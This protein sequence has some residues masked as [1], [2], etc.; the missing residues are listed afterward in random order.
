MAKKF[1]FFSRSPLFL[2][3]AFPFR[4]FFDTGTFGDAGVVVGF[5]IAAADRVVLHGADAVGF[6]VFHALPGRAAGCKGEQGGGAKRR[7]SIFHRKKQVGKSEQWMRLRRGYCSTEDFIASGLSATPKL[8]PAATRS[9]P[10][11]LHSPAHFR[12]PVPGGA[13]CRTRCAPHCKCPR[14]CAQRHSDC[15]RQ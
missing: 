8:P 11:R 14:C 1:H 5:V 15:L 13:S 3:G 9:I 12:R 7:K 10:G 4:V 2:F 6:W